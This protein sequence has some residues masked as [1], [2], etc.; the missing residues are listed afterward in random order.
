MVFHP[1]LDSIEACPSVDHEASILV[2]AREL[3]MLVTPDTL[4]YHH[5]VFF[6]YP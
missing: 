2:Q 6:L 5:W 3:L 4:G 1:A